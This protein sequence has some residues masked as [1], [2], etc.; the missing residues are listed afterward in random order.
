MSSR[1][2]LVLILT[3]LC[4]LNGHLNRLRLHVVAQVRS[5][6]IGQGTV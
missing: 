5:T 2:T 1:H 4:L 3:Q 6:A